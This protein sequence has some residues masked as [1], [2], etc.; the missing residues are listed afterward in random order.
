MRVLIAYDGSECADAAVVDLRKAG[1]PNDAEVLLAH[2]IDTGASISADPERQ[3]GGNCKQPSKSDL[4]N[5]KAL[6][7]NAFRWMESNYPGWS[8]SREVLW[9]SPAT[10]ILEKAH[11][12]HPDLIVVGSHGRS[13]TGRVFLG[14]VSLK[15]AHEAPCS[16][17]V[18]RSGS[19]GKGPIRIVAAIDGSSQAREVIEQLSRRVWPRET[20]VHLVSVV[21]SMVPVAVPLPAAG[22]EGTLANLQDS[23]QAQRDRFQQIATEFRAPLEHAG[24]IVSEALVEGNPKHELI[25]EAKR[26]K[27]DSIFVGARGLGRLEKLLLGSVSEAVLKH[28][29]CAV[30]IVRRS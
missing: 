30:E 28:A 9:G 4:R 17:R 25:E 8:S 27:A 14:S 20:E 29:S 13:L 21:E 2:V 1:I 11:S 23:P 24:L 7:H 3:A 12:W 15:L 5:G 26:W 10:V 19:I 22:W 16:V 6:T 18:V